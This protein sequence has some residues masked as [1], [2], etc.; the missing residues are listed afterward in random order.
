[1]LLR[2]GFKKVDFCQNRGVENFCTGVNLLLMS[3]Q[4]LSKNEEFDN[5]YAFHARLCYLYKKNIS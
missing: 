4:K 2:V 1:M 3:I 5:Q